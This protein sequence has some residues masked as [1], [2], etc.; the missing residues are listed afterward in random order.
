M[1]VFLGAQP[2]NTSPKKD[3]NQASLNVGELD[4]S[5]GKKRPPISLILSYWVGLAQTFLCETL[6][7]LSSSTQ[8]T[9]FVL[10]WCCMT[11]FS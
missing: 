1:V 11:Q 4:N 10:K 8:N 3:Q 7:S 5:E 9:T 6:H 2:F